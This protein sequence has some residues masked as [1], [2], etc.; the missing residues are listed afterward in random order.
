MNYLN[1]TNTKV[2]SNTFDDLWDWRLNQGDLLGVNQVK[3]QIV[4]FERKSDAV[5]KSMSIPKIAEE[6]MV[7]DAKDVAKKEKG[8]GSDTD[9]ENEGGS[10]PEMRQINLL[11]RLADMDAAALAKKMQKDLRRHQKGSS[12]ANNK[13]GPSRTSDDK[14]REDKND[15]STNRE[16]VDYLRTD[17]FTVSEEDFGSPR[18]KPAFHSKEKQTAT[19]KAT[20]LQLKQDEDFLYIGNVKIEAGPENLRDQF[21]EH[22]GA[23]SKRPSILGKATQR[24]EVAFKEDKDGDVKDEKHGDGGEKDK[25]KEDGEKQKEVNKKVVKKSGYKEKTGKEVEAKEKKKK[26]KDKKK[27]KRGDAIDPTKAYYERE[28]NIAKYY[29]EKLNYDCL[30]IESYFPYDRIPNSA[31]SSISDVVPHF[32][33]SRQEMS[34]EQKVLKQASQRLPFKYNFAA[35]NNAKKAKKT[36]TAKKHGGSVKESSSPNKSNMS[37]TSAG[38]QGKS[39]D[40]N[41]SDSEIDNFEDDYQ[42]STVDTMRG[43]SL[44]ME[45]HKFFKVLERYIKL[46]PFPLSDSLNKSRILKAMAPGP[47]DEKRSAKS[48]NKVEPVSPS[49]IIRGPRMATASSKQFSG[50]YDAEEMMVIEQFRRDQIEI[51]KA[52]KEFKQSE[53]THHDFKMLYVCIRANDT[54]HKVIEKFNWSGNQIMGPEQFTI[55]QTEKTIDSLNCQKLDIWKRGFNGF[56]YTCKRYARELIESNPVNGLLM[57]SVFLNTII[58]ALDGLTP[59]SWSDFFNNMNLAF[60]VL[61]TVEMVVKL[62]GYGVKQYCKDFFNIFDAFVVSI[63]MVELVINTMSGEQ[64]ATGGLRAVRIFRIFRV[65]RVTRLLRSLRFMRVIIDVLKGTAEQFMYIALLM[66][67][68]VFIFTLLGTQLFGGSFTF[69]VYDYAP[70]RFKFDSFSAAFFTVFTVL[71]VEN[72]NGVLVSCLRSEANNLISIVYLIAWIFIG[73]YIFI[74]LFLSILLEGFENSNAMQEFEELENESRE[75]ARVHKRL[76]K[77]AADKKA[78]EEAE[79]FEAN[80]KVQIITQPEKFAEEEVVKKNQACY[81]VVRN[82]DED[83]DSLSDHCDIKKYLEKGLAS[84]KPTIDP[85]VG[86][87]CYKSLFYLKKTHWLRLF[88]SKIV[89]HPK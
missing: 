18:D 89:A 8:S 39:T 2:P 3:K 22:F 29:S 54:D 24:L 68:F 80:K 84:H 31:F 71:T 77:E 79:Y 82:E 58:L 81:L 67:L 44:K 60:T 55:S 83:G 43:S 49:K 19:E 33:L 48:L 23:K 45:R 85:Y 15:N 56:V 66:F 4:T 30:K 7:Y 70:V 26:K 35:L 10:D 28:E 42:F 17:S 76:V 40:G 16:L 73:N 11:S 37:A 14:D 47:L 62:F 25:S 20:L 1:L 78:K 87:T 63:S 75:L 21:G 53:M 65:L 6:D 88:C 61:F 59:D 13:V 57:V 74:N 5:L 12:P 50:G 64:N 52:Y 86:V 72:W 41:S 46:K 51:D 9:S 36:K 27:E 69:D 38:S 34:Q 32:Y